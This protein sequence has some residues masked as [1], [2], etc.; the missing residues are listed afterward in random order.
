MGG[1]RGT[2]T[3]QTEGTLQARR[4]VHGVGVRAA[5]VGRTIVLPASEPGDI[6]LVVSSM[7]NTDNF[8]PYGI[9][10][11]VD[12]ELFYIGIR[13]N[14][15]DVYNI[16]RTGDALAMSMVG[17]DTYVPRLATNPPV[18]Y[19]RNG[20][21]YYSRAT[22]NPVR[23]DNNVVVIHVPVSE[24]QGMNTVRVYG[25]FY[26]LHLDP[27][28]GTARW[29]E[30]TRVLAPDTQHGTISGDYTNQRA[31][32]LDGMIFAL[33]GSTDA[34]S[35][36]QP[37][38]WM[39]EYDHLTD[40][41]AK[42]GPFLFGA[43]AVEAG[44]H[45]VGQNNLIRLD[46]T[47]LL[48]VWFGRVEGNLSS[49]PQ[50]VGHR[51]LI[52]TQILEYDT[53][54]HTIVPAGPVRRF[55]SGISESEVHV[56]Y[57]PDSG[58]LAFVGLAWDVA[59]QNPDGS[60]PEWPNDTEENI[61]A[62]TLLVNGNDVTEGHSRYR[63][64]TANRTPTDW[65][66][67]WYSC[68]VIHAAD[69]IVV[70]YPEVGYN[71]GGIPEGDIRY[72]K[73]RI[74][75]VGAERGGIGVADEGV[76]LD[77]SAGVHG[78][79]YGE[80]YVENAFVTTL[81]DG[82]N[83]TYFDH[84]RDDWNSTVFRAVIAR[85]GTAFGPPP[86]EEEAPSEFTI[87]DSMGLTDSIV[88]DLVAAPPGVS[89]WNATATA[90]AALDPHQAAAIVDQKIYTWYLDSGTFTG[91]LAIFD[92]QTQTWET[93]VVAPSAYTGAVAAAD[94]FIYLFEWD[95]IVRYDPATGTYS[96]ATGDVGAKGTR[97][98]LQDPIAVAVGTKVYVTGGVTRDNGFGSPL[99][100]FDTV[101][102]AWS[103][104]L[105][106]GILDAHFKKMTVSGTDIYVMGGGNFTVPNATVQKITSAFAV[107]TVAPLPGVRQG[108]SVGTRADGKIYYT[109]GLATAT[110]SPQA[111]HW[112]YD[113]VGDSWS[114]LT[115]NPVSRWRAF[116]VVDDWDDFY[117]IAGGHLS[118]YTDTTFWRS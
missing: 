114:T 7:L 52:H 11:E 62:R 23:L 39:I 43:K 59:P 91:R 118:T 63:V 96:A 32:Q 108:G 60:W 47:R 95:T 64:V 73:I 77:G 78:G 56:V 98:E 85:E 17:D 90:P 110:G 13:Q 80:P 111:N 70:M 109:G 81:A 113:P 103:T 49:I 69:R 16:N 41:Y 24:P 29:G 9:V 76:L 25:E 106:T 94:G 18:D 104:P 20:V 100:E 44:H 33:A 58:V 83:L 8:T 116:G 30:P 67:F 50:N 74:G 82:S 22:L 4:V 79:P 21:T 55:E 31:C 102:K 92:I 71:G 37:R 57:F 112:L 87:G 65:Q 38:V 26:A 12:G 46:D 107:S 15:G 10:E 51:G 54:A 117:V 34:A 40:T 88:V 3:L 1:R 115:A 68:A 35:G 5:T 53:V 89:G 101:T 99:H 2:L 36:Y 14:L 27:H 105:A 42:W 28:T 66:D 48:A 6:E 72:S 61:S 45:P 84:Y 75:Q 97:L 93:P 19:L 86:P